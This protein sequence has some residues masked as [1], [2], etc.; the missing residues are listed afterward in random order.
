MD[1]T[2]FI[3]SQYLGKYEY[4]QSLRAY[5]FHFE[6]NG[7]RQQEVPPFSNAFAVQGK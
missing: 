2:F 5:I 6:A 4:D 7:L 3:H 1:K